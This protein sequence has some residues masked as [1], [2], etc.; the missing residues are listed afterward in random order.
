MKINLLLTRIC[1][2]IPLL[3]CVLAG[4]GGKV[5]DTRGVRVARQGT[6]TLDGQPLQY[7]RVVFI[8]D[9]GS[10]AVKASAM[11]EDGSF[12]FTEENGPLE[13]TARVEIYPVEMELEDFE[14]QR[15]GDA[16][17]R[18]DVTRIDIP[19][20]YNVRSELTAEISGDG[21]IQPASFDLKSKR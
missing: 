12:T 19:P 11:V 7:A 5:E 21:V 6:V 14:T 10:G 20:R 3:V 18:I 13:G 15:G 17:K 1:P 2:L 4:C 9:Q 8:S 16:R